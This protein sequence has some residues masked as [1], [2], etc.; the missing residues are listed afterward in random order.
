MVLRPPHRLDRDANFD[1]RSHRINSEAGVS[2]KRAFRR[3]VAEEHGPRFSAGYE[4]APYAGAEPAGGE[5]GSS[6]TASTA[7]AACSQAGP[8]VGLFRS[9]GVLLY[10]VVPG[11]EELL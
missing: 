11:I 8:G 9:L 7:T 2:S 6:G 1:P 4:L 3:A 10:S 5:G